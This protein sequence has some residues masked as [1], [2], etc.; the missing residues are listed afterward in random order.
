VL[1]L[2]IAQLLQL[3]FPIY[4]FISA[5][6]VTDLDPAASRRLGLRRIW[7]TVI[8]ASCGAAITNVVPAGAMGVGFGLLV[9]MLLAQFSRR[10]KG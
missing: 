6:I 4:A 10:G 9:A 1:S 3:P 8:G 5:A 7:A 2:V